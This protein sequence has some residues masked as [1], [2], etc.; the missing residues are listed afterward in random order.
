[1]NSASNP[2]QNL[3]LP[4]DI[5]IPQPFS[6]SSD[7]TGTQQQHSTAKTQTSPE[8]NNYNEIDLTTISSNTSLSQEYQETHGTTQETPPLIIH[9]TLE[10][11]P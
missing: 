6:S 5:S 4:K 10:S 1:M 7:P 3:L 8:I 2:C 9:E 11:S